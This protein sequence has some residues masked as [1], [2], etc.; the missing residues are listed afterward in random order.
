MPTQ[1]ID[2][3]L[4]WDESAQAGQGENMGTSMI[5][6]SAI[7]GS[8]IVGL[9]VLKSVIRNGAGTLDHVSKPVRYFYRYASF[10]I[11][12]LISFMVSPALFL[13][14][15]PPFDLRES[16]EY[17]KSIA[18]LSYPLPLAI[19]LYWLLAKLA[20]WSSRQTGIHTLARMKNQGNI[21]I[22]TADFQEQ[23]SLFAEMDD[24]TNKLERG[25][26]PLAQAE[27]KMMALLAQQEQAGK[28][29]I[30]AMQQE[31]AAMGR[32]TLLFLLLVAL[33]AGAAIVV[34]LN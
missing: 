13:Q 23:D 30:E 31:R 11:C 20:R 22:G 32:R 26:M 24:I 19:V 28:R 12:F 6:I 18:M 25:E 21:V 2:R 34:A 29:R 16:P 10:G 8:G 27:E 17:A 33:A 15:L 1:L 4:G 14:F 3:W 7:L 9:L 5:A